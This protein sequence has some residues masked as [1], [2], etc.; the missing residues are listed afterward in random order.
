VTT[1]N[2][3]VTGAS[4]GIGSVVAARL[5]A[6]GNR[7]AL[8]AR[9]A[10][11]LSEV[12]AKMDGPAL[13]LPADVTDPAAADT[14][15]QAVE[16]EWG[17]VE[18]LVLNAG[19]AL[20]K[21]IA[22]ITDEE[23]QSQLDLNLIA[24]FRFMR[25]A[26]PSM[27]DRGWG[28]IVVIASVAAKVGEANIGAYTAS[29]HG[30]LGLVRTAAAELAKTGVTVNAICPGYVDTPMTDGNIELLAGRTGR[31]EQDIR[32]ALERKHP[33]R[34]LITTDEVADAVDLCVLSAGITGQGINVDGGM[35]Q[36]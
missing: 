8:T 22:G 34:R 33:I 23:F 31:P 5:S 27:V 29:K 24:P 3:L 17:P 1:R 4:R 32:H 30:V 7:V 9:G 20:A 14:I 21:P 2:C 28:R 6:A 19:A 11:Q 35:V 15:F 16:D 26:I 18:V 10:D 12:A 25:R 36:G 13:A